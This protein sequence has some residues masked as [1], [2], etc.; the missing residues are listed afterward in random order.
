VLV[1]NK[2][3]FVERDQVQVHWSK[4]FGKVPRA[5]APDG[6]T[7][8]DAIE[9]WMQAAKIAGHEQLVQLGDQL[10][11]LDDPLTTLEEM[12]IR[13]AQCR[14]RRH[15]RKIRRA[16]ADVRAGTQSVMETWFRC[17]AKDAGMPEPQ[18]NA[19]ILDENGN[20][21]ARSD[22]YWQ[23]L[24]VAGEYDGDHP[25]DPEQRAKD[26]DRRRRLEA[27][28]IVIITATKDDLRDP[29]RL[30]ADFQRAK[31]RAP[32]LRGKTR[33]AAGPR[34]F[35][36][37]AASRSDRRKTA[38][39]QTRQATRTNATPSPRNPAQ[40]TGGATVATTTGG[41]TGSGRA[42][43]ATTANA[44]NPGTRTATTAPTNPPT[45]T[46]GPSDGPPRPP[47]TA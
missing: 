42:T 22:L 11:R 15:I 20:W 4:E 37:R 36:A 31:G 43:P 14:G 1:S 41:T 17:R 33:A 30:I 21:L 8:C 3:P 24:Q 25:D 9:A 7:V 5:T 47:P 40:T 38:A 18:V 46:T 10:V 27:A 32:E 26:N 12:N 6:I 19:D 39:G 13:V 23:A 34:R 2:G 28:G 29:S 16:L 44:P 45:K 35:A